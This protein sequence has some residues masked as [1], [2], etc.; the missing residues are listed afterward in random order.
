MNDGLMSHMGCF[1]SFSVILL[2]FFIIGLGLFLCGVG[3]ISW[4]GF[5]VLP[6]FFLPS[7]SPSLPLSRVA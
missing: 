5:G 6:F 2:V 7:F 1:S 3:G 4:R